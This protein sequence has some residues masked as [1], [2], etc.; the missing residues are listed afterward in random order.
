MEAKNISAFCI[1]IIQLK[2]SSR[3]YRAE[4]SCSQQNF[5]EQQPNN[6]TEKTLVVGNSYAEQHQRGADIGG[7]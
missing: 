3:V 5:L 6:Y 1:N 4:N 2:K 7:S